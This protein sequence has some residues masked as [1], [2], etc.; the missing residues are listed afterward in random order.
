MKSFAVTIMCA[1]IAIIFLPVSISEAD[2][3][4]LPDSQSFQPDSTSD[5]AERPV[6]GLDM[7][8]VRGKFG[9]PE[10]TSGPIGHPAIT[11]WIYK[12]FTVVFESN[13]VIHTYVEKPVN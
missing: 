12:N 2:S 1:V 9:T 3:L 11:R 10:K 8:D 13:I 5:V 6:R 4:S 7:D